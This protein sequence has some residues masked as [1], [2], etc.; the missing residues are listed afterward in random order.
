MRKSILFFVVLFLSLDSNAQLYITPEGDVGIGINPN[1]ASNKL[2]VISYDDFSGMYMTGARYAQMWISNKAYS[3]INIRKGLYITN[4]LDSCSVYGIHVANSTTPGS[5]RSYGIQSIGSNSTT[6]SC[7]VFGGIS[8]Q[9][10]TCGAGI[11]G[12][13]SNGHQGLFN[14]Q[15][16]G[17]Y[18]G[19]FQGDVRVTGTLYGTL[20]TPT[21]SSSNHEN[22]GISS[23]QVVTR[24]S[25]MS[26]EGVSD[27]LR[28]VQLLS[29]HMEDTQYDSFKEE[30]IHESSTY[31]SL[32][33]KLD[34]GEEL[35]DEEMATLGKEM[36]AMA[37]AEAQSSTPQTRMASV[38]YGLDADQLK[39]VYPELI[40]EDSKGNISVNYIEMVPLLVQSMN[41]MQERIDILEKD[42]AMLR[43]EISGEEEYAKSR[44]ES[45]G[46]DETGDIDVLSLS[47]NDPNPF[48]ER[49]T[50]TLNIPKDITT[51][52]VFFYDMSGKQIG[53]RMITERGKTQI[54][55]T[56]TDFGEGMYLYSLIADGKVIATRKMIL[57]K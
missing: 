27:K 17:R 32:T 54:S 12:S 50:I 31:K 41:E 15:Y 49:T 28:Q 36:E 30:E 40:Y 57:T 24:N 37:E 52:A 1:N 55:V 8:G 11:V 35:T 39:K 48:S 18:A 3:M 53:K 45:T 16:S 20:L 25:D 2:N 5:G 38:R 19:F 13:S 56:S 44:G 4:K 47:Q 23:I 7:G 29:I 33:A 21:Q 46:L 6:L 14:N 43:A 51:A 10:I 26:D 34:K 42:N 9:D 22:S